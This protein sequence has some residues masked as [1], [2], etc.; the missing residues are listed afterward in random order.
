MNKNVKTTLIIIIGI[1]ALITVV[2]IIYGMQNRAEVKNI[3]ASYDENLL[4]AVDYSVKL[5]QTVFN[6]ASVTDD[7]MTNLNDY[8]TN[9]ENAESPVLKAYIADS[10]L[11]YV[12][13]F[14]TVRSQYYANGEGDIPKA[15]F[16][17]IQERL[18]SARTSLDA[19]REY[20]NDTA[21]TQAQ[22]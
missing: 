16:T 3:Y 11:T 10:M 22:N 12:G 8:V 4:S 21:T 14:M 7:D 15:N 2:G 19:A 18:A 17:G 5:C 20:K 6:E 9:I 13:D 1:L